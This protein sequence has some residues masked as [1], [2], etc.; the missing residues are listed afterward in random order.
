MTMNSANPDRR[1]TNPVYLIMWLLPGATVVASFVTLFIALASG[2]RALPESY[3]WEGA[4]LDADFARARAAAALGIEVRFDARDG[5]CRAVVRRVPGDPASLNVLLTNGAD[6][7][8]DRRLRLTRVAPD[9]YRASCAPVPSGN[10]RVALDDDSHTW[11]LRA[12]AT[13][14]MEVFEARA[15]SPDGTS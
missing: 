15:R 6:A 9:D 3:H 4:R 12:V 11:T 14:N 2:D 10:W 7:G 8:L 1:L 5:Q 13:G